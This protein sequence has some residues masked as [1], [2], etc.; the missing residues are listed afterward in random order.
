MNTHSVARPILTILSCFL[1]QVSFAQI[2]S[3]NFEGFPIATDQNP[4]KWTTIA[5]DCD[6]GGNL[7]IGSGSSQWG[8]YAGQF[9]VNDIEGFP[10][11]SPGGG[12]D[13]SWLSEV[14]DL[15]GFCDISIS[16]DVTFDAPNGMECNDPGSPIFGCSSATP[17]DN[18]HDQVVVEYNLDGGG[19]VQFGYVCGSNGV[20][21]I[22][23]SGLNGSTLEL[24]F[25]ASCKSNGEW[26]FIDNIVVDGSVAT[27]PTFTQIGPLCELEPPVVLPTSSTE[28]ITGTWDIGATFDPAGLGNS[29]TTINFTPDAGQCASATTMIITVDPETILNPPAVGPFCTT[30][31]PFNLVTV[32]NGIT[33]NWSGPGVSGNV[34]TPSV[35]GGNVNIT[36]TPDAGECAATATVA[37]TVDT[38]VTPTLGSTTLCDNEPLYDLSA[39]LDPN[40]PLGTWAGP[41]VSG[42]NFDPSGQGGNTVNITF[43]SSADCTNLAATT[44]TVTESETPTL[45][46]VSI[47]VNNG[48]FDLTGLLDPNFPLGTWSGTGVSGNFFNPTNQNGNVQV[49]FTSTAACTNP[50]TTTITVS[51]I[52]TPVLQSATTCQTSGFFDLTTLEDPAFPGGTWSGPGV[53]GTNF[54]PSN[55]N[56][57]VVLTYTFAGMCVDPST[58]TITVDQPTTPQLGTANICESSGLYDLTQLQDPIFPLG[59][60]SGTNVSGNMFDPAGL[61]GSVSLTFTSSEDC[62]FPASTLIVVETAVTPQLGTETLCETDTLFDLT[63]IQDPSFPSGN[64]SGNGVTGINFDPSGLSGNVDLTFIATGNCVDTASTFITV[65]T[66]GLPQ[67]DTAAICETSG[68]FNLNLLTDPNF[69]VGTWSGPG[70]T[71]NNFDP[72]GLS[73]NVNLIFAASANCSLP[74]STFIAVTVPAVPQLDSAN[75]CQNN[76]LFN[77]SVLVDPNYPTGTWSGPGVTGNNFD[78]TNQSGNVAVTFTPS[79]D[80]TEAGTT[81]IDI[82]GAPTFS[83]QDETCDL[84]TQ[85]FTVSFDISGG[86]A[87]YILDGDTLAG[88]NFTSTAFPSGTNY[89]FE[90]NDINECG[91]VTISGSANCACATDAGTMDFT[92]APLMIC[93]SSAVEVVH[94]GNEMLDPNDVLVF[95]LH[96]SSGTQLGNILMISD[97]TIIPYPDS[98]VLGQ[99][100]YISAVAGDNDGNGGVDTSDACLSVSQ[101]IPVIFYIPEVV[102]SSVT[103]VCANG[104]FDVNFQ[105]TG[106]GAFEANYTIFANSI[107]V[108]NSTLTDVQNGQAT[109][110]ICPS[111]YGMGQGIIEVIIT[112]IAD[113]NCIVIPDPDSTFVEIIVDELP[114][115]NF[116]PTYCPGQSIVIN[117]T[118]YDENNP[119]GTETFINGSSLGCDSII[120]VNLTYFP[121]AADSVNQTLCTG[122]SI[123]VNG[124]VYNGNNPNGTEVIAAGGANGCDSTIFVNLT[125]N[126]EVFANL[127]PLLCPGGSITI[128]GTAYNASNPSGSETF[129]N[130]SV[131]GCDSTVIINIAFHPPATNNIAPSLCSGGSITV[132]GTVY[133]ENNPGGTEILPNASINGCDSIINVSLN[134]TDEVVENVMPLLCLNDSVTVN[135][136]VYDFQNPT[137]TETIVNGSYLGCDS[138][139]LVALDFFPPSFLIIEEEFCAGTSITVNGTVYDENNPIGQEW[140]IGGASTG[141]DSL[142]NIALSFVIE[143]FGNL[144][145]TLC[146]NES[147]TINGTVYD[148]NNP[149]GTE[150]IIGGSQMGCDTTIFIALDF[151]PPAVNTINDFLCP[152]G[153]ITVNGVVYDDNNPFGSETIPNASALGCDSIVN[154]SLGFF[155]VSQGNFNG[156]LCTGSSITINGTLYDENNPSGSEFFQNAS[157]NGCDS[158]LF[159]NIN[160]VDE[161]IFNLADTLCPDESIT[162]NGVEYGLNNPMGSETIQGGSSFGCDSTIQVALS[163]HPESDTLIEET[164]LPGSS[165]TINGVVYN[166]ANPSGVDVIPNGSFTGCDSTIFVNIIFEGEIVVAFTTNPPACEFGTDGS[167]TIESISGGQEPYVVAINGGSSMPVISLP[168]VFDNLENGFY[169]LIVVD[170]LGSIF[171]EDIFLPFPTPPVF[172][173]GSDIFI[174]LGETIVLAANTGFVP[175]AYLWEPDTYLDCTDCDSPMA[176]PANDISYTLTITDQNGCTFS[177]DINVFVTK[178]RFVYGPNVFSPN[179]DGINDEFTLFTGNQVA[180]IN[181]LQIFDR[182]GGLMFENFEF[183]PNNLSIGWD[184]RHKGQEMNPAVF[185][186]F[187]KVEFLDGQFA[188]FK[189]DV[190]L[191]R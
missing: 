87:P 35:A 19:F 85:T 139:I 52:V 78:P 185:T 129:P 33:G 17:P 125:F 99:T 101:G 124:T 110:N 67:L 51:A 4:P 189:G 132:N 167:I 96:D 119:T 146:S 159:V 186:W 142:V 47:C 106:T 11:C 59:N 153:S 154:I 135:G 162:V 29:T 80:C 107:N 13:N 71:G 44:I 161:V 181:R 152:G 27:T 49:T 134:F 179:N 169:S 170:A 55:Q 190:T 117:G 6:D 172:D 3:E 126:N 5:T 39:L 54:D 177:D 182:W 23:I 137:G 118:Q 31:P 8:V 102:L 74:D 104:C 175:T 69:P 22:N 56:G 77:L 92:N 120:N 75:I 66:S 53:T 116:T 166:Q 86:T 89:S 16:L 100:Y 151:H 160:F 60:W 37:V 108:E 95:V 83:N 48:L 62:T 94:L 150:T 138:V 131:F 111:N 98:I 171:Q 1:I 156:P 149:T 123:T 82:S 73:G 38:P 34:F 141:C 14:I 10:C 57:L 115:E 25:F 133:D 84:Q 145:T 109:L 180:K 88:N 70:V 140:I 30:D 7:N 188:L 32:I 9:T 41:G 68:L 168:L 42:N 26:Y 46:T 143:V 176:T 136:T 148:Q 58:T 144:D 76:G 81:N 113:S 36:F 173:L 105:F 183:E 21:P 72:S 12:N 79:A 164:L 2:W 165:I 63:M 184:G 174:D 24:R 158:T 15:N 64:W 28:S 40:Y 93:D 157:V 122:S 20:G 155:P 114:Q 112:E 191:V 121:P 103:N 50:A 187:A 91:P 18:S 65:D 127:N 43:T 61:N 178:A 163:F 45:G 128:N 147:I 97:T 90:L 130:G